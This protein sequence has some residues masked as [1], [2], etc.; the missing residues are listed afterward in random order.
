VTIVGDTAHRAVAYAATV[1]AAGFVLGML[2]VL[3]VVPRIGTR[4]AELIELPIMLAVAYCAAGRARRGLS[5]QARGRRLAIG[6]IG[7]LLVLGAEV[8]TGMALRS[9]S[10]LG[11]L[12]NPDPVSGSL[13][14]MSLVLVAALPALRRG[15]A[16]PARSC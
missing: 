2:R 11:A 10:V 16:P 6:V 15:T 13:Y 8:A 12:I 3:F 9:T 7:L 4:A 5:D 14:Y 1:F